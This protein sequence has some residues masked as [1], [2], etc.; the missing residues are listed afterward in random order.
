MLYFIFYNTQSQGILK[1]KNYN[2]IK[3]SSGNI[4]AFS[5]KKLQRSIMRSGLSPVFSKKI[6]KKIAQEIHPGST[7]KEIYKKT[8]SLIKKKS[9]VAAT[10]YSLKRSLIELGPTGYE[11]EKLIAKYFEAIGYKTQTGIVVEGK[12]VTHEVDVIATKG[13]SSLFTECKFH[14]NGGRKNDIKIALYVKA[15]WDDLSSGPNGS[16]IKGYYL[17]SN[18]AFTKDAITYSNGVGLNLLGVNAPQ[19]ESL[20]DK[21]KIY[22]LYPITS[23]VRIKKHYIQLLLKKKIILCSELIK[24]RTLLIKLGMPKEEIQQL[25]WDIENLLNEK[26]TST[27][28]HISEN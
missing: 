2:Q 19:E 13:Q 12:F 24:Q 4:E 15:R 10:H 8:I 9:S 7:T 16:T 25:F 22:K 5:E 27:Q 21:I 6:S 23:L 11:F 28:G 1:L 14:N 20:L 26:T 18:T 3:K 17:A